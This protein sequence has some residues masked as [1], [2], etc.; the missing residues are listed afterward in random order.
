MSIES[1][2]NLLLI[3]ADDMNWDAV[4][5]NGCETEGT[6]PNLDRLANE[7]IRFEHGHV[8]IAVC[9]PSRSA[10]MTGRY[11]HKS[12]GEGFYDL[13]F[14]GVPILPELLRKE[15][16]RVGILG[17]VGHST[18][19]SD[20]KWDHMLDM[21]DLGMGRSV[22][23]YRREIETF[24]DDCGDQPFFMMANSHD[25]HRPFV[26][27]DNEEWY[28][29]TKLSPPAVPPS[30]TFSPDEVV[31]PGFLEDLPEVRLEIS[32]YYSSVRRCDD[33]VGAIL[34]E[35]EKKGKAENTLILFL[36]DNGMAFPFA[37]TNC[38]LNS[39]KTPFLVRWPA[40]VKGERVESGMVSGIDILPTFLDAAGAS[41]PAEVQGRSFLPLLR[42]E[43]QGD[44]EWVYTHFNQNYARGNFPMRAVQSREWLY[45]FNPWSDGCKEFKNESMSGR[46]FKAM[47]EAAEENPKIAERVEL[48][49]HRVPE[50]LYDLRSDPHARNNLVGDPESSE[51]LDVCR[52]KL[53]DEMCRH[54]DPA[55]ECFQHR[56]DEE[57][58]KA[59]ME[60][61]EETLAG[62]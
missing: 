30:R 46:T 28:D 8:T 32:E 54:E 48:F 33:T 27:N 58:R 31:V 17:K 41:L 45:V 60:E 34:A 43:E 4:G 11:P 35:L 49:L 23:T 10:M 42:G 55:L 40:G 59:F 15:G 38:Y 56:G 52:T 22:S 29:E 36:S 20:F 47:K 9:Q 61:F 25:P 3:T 44:R 5:A 14:P 26:G 12:G 39:T 51:I 19:Y 1:R 37:K 62:Y 24:L 16:Y 21:N 53:E 13:R 6:T 18:P 7:G 50:E 57:K 2:P